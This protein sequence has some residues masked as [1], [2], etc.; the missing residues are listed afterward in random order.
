MHR[1]IYTRYLL[2]VMC[3][4]SV[5]MVSQSFIRLDTMQLAAAKQQIIEG[6]ASPQTL[7]AYSKLLQQASSVLKQDNPT[8]MDKTIVPPSGDKHDYLSI[9]RYWWPDPKRQDGLPWIRL[10]GQTNP[11]TQTE[12]VDRKRLALMG[13]GVYVLSLAY[14][15]TEDETYATKAISMLD[16]WFINPETLMNPHLKFGQSIPGHPNTRPF[17]ILDGRSIVQFIPDAL[18]LIAT[19]TQW[20]INK[21]TK[22]TAWLSAYLAWLI[23]SPLG[24]KGSQLTNN[25]GSWYKFQVTALAMYLGQTDLAKQTI[26]VTEHS[27]E[28]MLTAEGGQIHELERTRSF[29]YSCFNLEALTSIAKIGDDV[30]MNMWNYK[31]ENNKSLSLALQYLAPVVNGAEWKHNTLKTVN[32]TDL[33]PIVA[34]FFDTYKTEDYRTLLR[35]ILAEVDKDSR[36]ANSQEFWLFHPDFKI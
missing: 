28:N 17:G 24:I 30:D 7:E 34:A 9:S 20:T 1:P 36:D 2:I 15:F 35:S 5:T 10:D 32:K 29:F 18:Q 12:A 3:L 4:F 26:V 19:S 27:L 14:Y 23:E 33:L 6:T 22:M 13:R 8:V 31:T 16:T 11:E 21:Q 25:H